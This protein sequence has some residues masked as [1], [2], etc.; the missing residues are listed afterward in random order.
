MKKSPFLTHIVDSMYQRHYAKKSIE[1]Y[2]HWIYRFICFHQKRHP[3]EI[4]RTRK[5]TILKVWMWSFKENRQSRCFN[6]LL[7]P[8]LNARH[9]FTHFCRSI[10]K[11]RRL[12][13]GLS[14]T[15]HYDL[16]K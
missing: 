5:I 16:Q 4:N 1:S 13:N 2:V 10:A 12:S 9:L 15:N 7:Y 6:L 14:G 8:R 3:A 11:D